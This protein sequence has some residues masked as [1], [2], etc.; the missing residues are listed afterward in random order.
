MPSRCRSCNAPIEWAHTAKGHRIPLDVVAG[1]A[2]NLIV[3]EHGVAHY[4]ATGGTHTS[5][6][7]TCPDATQHRQPRPKRGA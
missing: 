6:F 2:P 5:H 3:D 7:A 1:P 4:A